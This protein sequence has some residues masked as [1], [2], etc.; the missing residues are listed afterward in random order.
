MKR[1]VLVLG[2]MGL[3]ACAQVLG[4]DEY[5]ESGASGS[6]TG[7]GGN[8]SGSSTSGSETTTNASGATSGATSSSSGEGGAPPSYR[9]KAVTG[10]AE[11]TCALLE[12][13]RV[14]CWGNNDNGQ[15][16]DG[17][18]K[19]SNTPVLVQGIDTAQAVDAGAL[20]TCALLMSGE[21]RCWGNNEH[22]E[23]GMFGVDSNV[24]VTPTGLPSAVAGVTAGGTH[25]C[26]FVMNGR[27][28]C[29]G[30]NAS[31]QLGRNTLGG[32]TH[33]ALVDTLMSAK[34][35]SAGAAHTCAAADQ[36]TMYCW[37]SNAFQQVGGTSAYYLQPRA[38]GYIPSPGPPHSGIPIE[39][40]A[41]STCN[42]LPT[43]W[44]WGR[45]VTNK[46]AA[47][48][49]NAIA[50]QLTNVAQ[51]AGGGQH[52]CVRYQNGTLDCWGANDAGQLGNGMMG[53]AT[54]TEVEPTGI[55]DAISVGLGERHSCAVVTTSGEPAVFCWG[56]NDSGQLGDGSEVPSSVPVPVVSMP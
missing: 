27:A 34:G 29:W 9:A 52:F 6:T 20:H 35:I 38:V 39:A 30:G 1:T 19:S 51:L 55:A 7:S 24:P 41:D 40:A 17:T 32:S 31:G 8:G 47:D 2:A 56:A 49:G 48:Q 43:P 28:Y 13:G 50:T 42:R 33:V 25:T 5:S 44:C 15:L 18:F 10:G 46:Q 16:G 3:V 14:A 12:D 37:G 54:T 22:Q 21:V 36:F 45:Q 53:A 4:L 23:L 26:V 11:H